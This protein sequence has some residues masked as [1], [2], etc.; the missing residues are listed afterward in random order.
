MEIKVKNVTHVGR[1]SP[2]MLAHHIGHFMAR[3][4]YQRRVDGEG[5][6]AGLSEYCHSENTD[7]GKACTTATIRQTASVAMQWLRDG[8]KRRRGRPSKT[9][10]QTFQED[11]QECQLG[12][13]N[14]LQLPLDNRP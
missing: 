9:W 3:S 7:A 1:L 11:L 13:N 5:W 8:G 12:Y 4:R 14:F 6:D 2:K 10:R